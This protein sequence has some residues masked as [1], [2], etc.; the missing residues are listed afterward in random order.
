VEDEEKEGI[1]EGFESGPF[2]RH[3]SDPADC[4]VKCKRCGHRC[5][6]HWNDDGCEE[7]DCNC[8]GWLEDDKD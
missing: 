7:D 8:I 2:C 4:D 6:R 3:W 5:C 1:E